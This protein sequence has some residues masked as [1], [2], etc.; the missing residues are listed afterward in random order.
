MAA[1]K[2]GSESN[3]NKRLPSLIQSIH[4]HVRFSSTLLS[5]NE[6]YQA[7]GGSRCAAPAEERVGMGRK[8]SAS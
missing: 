7:P 2:T 3:G 4:F 6:H 5:D 1:R 8:G